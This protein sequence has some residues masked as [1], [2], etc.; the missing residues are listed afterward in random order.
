MPFETVVV[1]TFRRKEFLYCCLAY[2]R[3][4]DPAIPIAIFPDQATAIDQELQ[5]I[6]SFFKAKVCFVPK[7][8][9]YGNSFNVLEALRA[10]F[11]TGFQRIYYIEDDVFVH[12]DFFAWHRRVQDDYP[13]IFASMAWVFNRHAP[14][15]DDDM[16]QPWYYA[17]G[18]CFSIYALA[19]IVEHASPLYYGNMQEYIRENF[20]DSK[21]NDPHVLAHYEQD[22]LIQ[23]VLEASGKQTVSSGIAKCSH[24][25]FAGYN[26]GWSR[27][28]K[29][30]AGCPD[31]PERIK[32][33][34]HCYAD[35]YWR[36]SMFGR[37]VVERELGREIP[38][39]EIKYTIK[40]PD[41]WESEFTSEMSRD[42]LPLRVNSIN[43]PEDSQILVSE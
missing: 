25:G 23:R 4:A 27:Y 40:L 24:M 6:A 16:F 13:D 2:I 39:R 3:R 11:N 42:Y 35:P 14:I 5:N 9:Y 21:I 34:E 33:I 19:Q 38:K 43:I 41:G 30:F 12:P 31:F 7:H 17:I 20:K 29:F 36:V 26:R 15:S 8:N 37:E 22:G 28:D 32:R 1:P 18:T 10:A